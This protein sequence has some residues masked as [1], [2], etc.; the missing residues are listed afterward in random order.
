MSEKKLKQPVVLVVFIIYVLILLFLLVIPNNYRAHNV[1][2]GGL[3]WEMWVE[4]IKGGFNFVPFRSI[5]EQVG[6]IFDGVDVAR[7]SIYLIGNLIGF[8]PLG[9]FLPVLFARQRRFAIFIVTVVVALACLELA[10]LLTMRGSFD[11]DDIILNTAGALL[12]FWVTRKLVGEMAGQ[13][14]NA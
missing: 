14:P 13:K 11:I 3:S 12:G 10:Q 6:F 7:N 5:A 8:A 2:V 4:Y 1:F 9:F